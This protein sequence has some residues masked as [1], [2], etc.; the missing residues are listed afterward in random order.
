[1]RLFAIHKQLGFTISDVHL[2]ASCSTFSSTERQEDHQIKF[3][4]E[5]VATVNYA[6]E[7]VR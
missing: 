6:R 4:R 3:T 1:M 7:I 5:Y 2:N